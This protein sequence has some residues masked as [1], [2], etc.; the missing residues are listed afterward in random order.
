MSF[1]RRWVRCCLFWGGRC[2][3][4]KCVCILKISVETTGVRV[5]FVSGNPSP[6]V[7]SQL[8]AASSSYRFGCRGLQRAGFPSPSW[9]LAPRTPSTQLS[10]S[11]SAT[12]TCSGF[13]LYLSSI[14]LLQPA[15][16]HCPRGG[17]WSENEGLTGKGSKWWGFACSWGRCRGGWLSI[18]DVPGRSQPWVK[19]GFLPAWLL[20]LN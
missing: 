18:C 2:W 10:A 6:A 3:R 11:R 12:L 4:R 14:R 15:D 13:E 7:P 16:A 8:L 19:M 20:I 5:A 9:T 17:V 1:G